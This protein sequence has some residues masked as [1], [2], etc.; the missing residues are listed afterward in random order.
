MSRYTAPDD[1]QA[2]S[3]PLTSHSR[4]NKE[5]PITAPAMKKDKEADSSTVRGVIGMVVAVREPMKSPTVVELEVLALDVLE[6]EV[7]E[8]ASQLV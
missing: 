5:D 1:H 2:A 4:S 8:G 6:E 3:S 7:E